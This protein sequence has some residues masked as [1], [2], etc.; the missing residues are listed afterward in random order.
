MLYA[1]FPVRHLTDSDLDGFEE[2]ENL[3]AGKRSYS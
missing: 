1:T 3:E 2:Y